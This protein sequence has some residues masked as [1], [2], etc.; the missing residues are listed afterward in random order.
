MLQPVSARLCAEPNC[1]YASQGP[2]IPDLDVYPRHSPYGLNDQ[3]I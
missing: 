2:E 1:R 3:T